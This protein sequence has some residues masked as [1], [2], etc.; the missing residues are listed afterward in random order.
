MIVTTDQT[1]LL[2]LYALIRTVA[3]I[4]FAWISRPIAEVLAIVG[5]FIV[6]AILMWTS[7][8]Y[9]FQEPMHQDVPNGCQ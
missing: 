6:L 9:V 5:C 3:G 8:G 2:V 7:V 4:H 1:L